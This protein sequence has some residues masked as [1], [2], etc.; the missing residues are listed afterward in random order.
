MSK[1]APITVAIPTHKARESLFREA[2]N[3]VFDQTLPPIGGISVACDTDLEGAAPTRQRA[4]NAVDTEYVAFL[5]SDDYFYPNHL[6]VLYN[7]IIVTNSDYAYS[8][9]D[10]NNPFPKHRGRQF[11]PKN[12]HQTTM[13]VLVK[14]ELAKSV[15]FVTPRTEEKFPDGNRMGEDWRFTL[16]CRDLGAK[17]IGTDQITWHY[18]VHSG[19]TS[20]LPGRGDAQIVYR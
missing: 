6:E 8:W 15:G 9:F 10:G 13:T 5:D 14:T 17:F 12:P 2:V 1:L 7:L 11:D 4:L 16:G 19:N 18:R 20:G 3:S